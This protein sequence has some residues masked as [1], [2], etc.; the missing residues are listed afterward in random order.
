MP[1]RQHQFPTEAAVHSPKPRVWAHISYL[2]EAADVHKPEHGLVC[3]LVDDDSPVVETTQLESTIGGTQR[4][5]IDEQE[6]LLG[7]CI[8]LTMRKWLH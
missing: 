3:R 2:T 7:S 6:Q 4:V 5:L 8:P 1:L